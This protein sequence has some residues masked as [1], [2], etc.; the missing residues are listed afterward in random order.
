MYDTNGAYLDAQL[1]VQNATYS[2][3]FYDP[4]TTPATLLTTINNSTDNGMIQEDWGVTNA[5]GTPFTGGAVQAV[6]DVTPLDQSSGATMAQY[7]SA[8]T[9]MVQQQHSKSLHRIVTREHISPSMYDGFDVV[10]FYTPTN[11]D[12]S[13]LNMFDNGEVWYGMLGVVDTLTMPNSEYDGYY[14]YFNNYGWP[15][16]F[17][18]YPGYLTSQ[19][20]VNNTLYSDLAN[21]TTKNFYGY[22]H[23]NKDY[24]GTRNNEVFMTAQGVA[25]VLAN[26]YNGA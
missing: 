6:F 23:G 20:A 22:G 2:I 11:N 13:L 21:G 15:S 24:L 19:A 26:Q 25:K 1:A 17:D 4:S 14:S 3:A 18:G 16:M 5:D 7:R 12:S 10:Y 8:T 9:V